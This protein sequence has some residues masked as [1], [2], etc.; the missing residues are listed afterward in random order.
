MPGAAHRH[1][2]ALTVKIY[3]LITDRP[4]NRCSFHSPGLIAKRPIQHD[5]TEPLTAYRKLNNLRLFKVKE[6]KCN[7]LAV[8]A[9][10]IADIYFVT[11]LN[12]GVRFQLHI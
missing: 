5:D 10:F 4:A 7:A 12:D 3:L 1:C 2:F 8:L 9:Y 11:A 6:I